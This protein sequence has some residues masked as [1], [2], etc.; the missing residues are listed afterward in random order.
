MP[1]PDYVSFTPST[2]SSS[3]IPIKS[4]DCYPRRF[5]QESETDATTC[6]VGTLMTRTPSPSCE[7]IIVSTEI[8][9]AIEELTMSDGCTPS[10]QRSLAN[11]HKSSSA[12]GLLT[13]PPG[14]ILNRESG[15]NNT[16]KNNEGWE[17]AER[18][19]EGEKKRSSRLQRLKNSGLFGSLT[20]K[21]SSMNN[22]HSSHP[23]SYSRPSNV[24]EETGNNGHKE[25]R[26]YSEHNVR[27]SDIMEPP[28][29]NNEVVLEGIDRMIQEESH[30]DSML[31]DCSRTAASEMAPEIQDE[32]RRHH[33]NREDSK[34][35]LES[36][37]STPSFHELN[38]VAAVCA[39][40]CIERQ[41]DR[42]RWSSIPEYAKK[43][44]LVGKC[45]GKGTFR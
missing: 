39:R 42:E 32:E 44:L 8:Q 1:P 21:K 37:G 16:V 17:R 5:T 20:R 10:L 24:V 30:N 41:S 45:L 25:I 43:D 29:E 34:S 18:A 3:D 6:T 4:G 2:T 40:E 26:P 33:H 12:P 27:L 35:M 19:D 36:L 9:A 11:S 23:V 31:S 14:N 22:N 38:E 13:Q 7:G 15:N 28:K